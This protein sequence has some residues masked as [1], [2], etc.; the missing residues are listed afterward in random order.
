MSSQFKHKT[1][2]WT[3]KIQYN[4][5][6]FEDK[7]IKFAFKSWIFKIC[8]SKKYLKIIT[9]NYIRSRFWRSVGKNFI[10]IEQE[11][12]L[13]CFEKLWLYTCMKYS[14]TITVTEYLLHVS[15]HEMDNMKQ[16]DAILV[17]P[18]L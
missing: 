18:V 17:L 7:T 3:S 16:P 8:A 2:F 10:K 4:D 14:K 1:K 13:E 11:L 12:S 6:T 15:V 9:E 5:S